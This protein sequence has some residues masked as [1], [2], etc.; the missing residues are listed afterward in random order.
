MG[1]LL[2]ID[3]K[4]MLIITLERY[5]SVRKIAFDK[6]ASDSKQ[7][8]SDLN[9][10]GLILSGGPGN[11]K[12]RKDLDLNYAALNK[13]DVP[14]LGICL[15]HQILGLHY[16][17]VIDKLPKIRI[18]FDNIWI[19][20]KDPLFG[21]LPNEIELYYQHNYHLTSV[22]SS[23]EVLASSD[24]CGIEVIKVKD[25]PVYGFQS[26][27]EVSGRDGDTILDNFL[28]ICGY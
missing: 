21:Y 20:T 4:S 19:N 28:F 11:P 24:T 17:S 9:V 12:T 6:I 27:P 18:G 5:L 22:N 25:K 16:G 10:C 26:H 2:I 1:K 23:L 3:N 13:F 8:I 14:T 7:D 15:G